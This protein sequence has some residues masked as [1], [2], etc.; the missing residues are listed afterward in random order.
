MSTQEKLAALTAGGPMWAIR[1]SDQAPPV[2]GRP[3]HASAARTEDGTWQLF[4]YSDSRYG[5]KRATTLWAGTPIETVARTFVDEIKRAQQS[6]RAL[7]L[8]EQ[9][10]GPKKSVVDG[11][12]MLIIAR[13][14]TE[15]KAA[16]ERKKAEAKAKRAQKRLAAK[17]AAEKRAA[18]VEQPKP[19][20]V[21]FDVHGIATDAEIESVLA[22]ADMT[23]PDPSEYGE[24][25]GGRVWADVYTPADL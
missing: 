6:L 4:A 15:L 13:T 25:F 17:Q 20:A 10:T 1:I 23:A 19:E 22:F 16:E 5:I 12:R 8:R 9:T 11:N 7:I 21:R 2:F 18:P 14:A 3:I 24:D